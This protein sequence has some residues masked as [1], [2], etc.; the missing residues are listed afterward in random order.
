MLSLKVTGIMVPT[1]MRISVIVSLYRLQYMLLLLKI[2]GR[3]ILVNKQLADK[4]EVLMTLSFPITRTIHGTLKRD[5][6][7]AG[8][9]SG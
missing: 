7:I 8:L 3:C 5:I 4:G 6:K 9:A 2:R 1:M